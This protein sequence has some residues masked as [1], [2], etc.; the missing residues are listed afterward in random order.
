MDTFDAYHQWLGIPP[1]EQPPSAYRLLGLRPLESDSEVIQNAA[2]RQTL[3]LRTYQLGEHADISERLLNEVAAARLLLLNP[4]KK[5][6][7]DRELSA[8]GKTELETPAFDQA[9]PSGE[10]AML[11]VP[12]PMGQVVLAPVPRR[13]ARRLLRQ[14][15]PAL[16]ALIL[17]G[18]SVMLLI[19]VVGSWFSAVHSTPISTD[20]NGS[21]T[22]VPIKPE[23][24]TPPVRPSS[25]RPSTDEPRPTIVIESPSGR[26]TGPRSAPSGTPPTPKRNMDE[27]NPGY[28]VE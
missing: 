14:A 2:D 19:H 28:K 25:S 15:L 9:A 10:P 24:E 7:Y 12:R 17:I 11:G 27:P 22:S 13:R 18:V 6:E 8:E 21:G 26:P 23:Q 5:A 3:H 20:P 1:G 4:T 16:V